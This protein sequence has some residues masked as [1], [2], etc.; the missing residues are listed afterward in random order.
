MPRPDDYVPPDATTTGG[1]CFAGC[2]SQLL[3]AVC[4]MLTVAW[5]LG[6]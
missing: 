5:V 6:W 1:C 4:F 2:A 3:G